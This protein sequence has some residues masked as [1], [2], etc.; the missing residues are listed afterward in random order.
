MNYKKIYESLICRAKERELEGYKERHHIIPCCMFIGGRENVEANKESNLVYLTPQEH[1]VCHQ[2]LVKMFPKFQG[3][4]YALN[5]LTLSSKG[6]VRTN[7]K[8]A[9]VRRKF[10]EA[11]KGK[12]MQEITCNPNW[13]SP[14][15]GQP[16]TTQI[17]NKGKVM[18]KDWVNPKKGK[19][20]ED[21]P[22]SKNWKPLPQSYSFYIISS[23]GKQLFHS[24]AQCVKELGIPQKK[25]ALLL[26]E[27]FF[28]IK[29]RRPTTKHKWQK[30]EKVYLE[31][32]KS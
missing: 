32:V 15:K 21:Y 6:Q 24:R 29:E 20:K 13:V 27:G 28:E 26:K 9:W 30:G 4:V 18:P 2:L 22:N 1:F 19:S 11:R 14:R 5:K 17:W 23:L 16:R 12:T 3:L 7:K 31:M 25:F 8:Y 10:V